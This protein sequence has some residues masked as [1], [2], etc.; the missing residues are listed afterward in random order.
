MKNKKFRIYKY[1]ITQWSDDQKCFVHFYSYGFSP[2]HVLERHKRVMNH[3]QMA[4]ILNI[5]RLKKIRKK[6]LSPLDLEMFTDEAKK[7][8]GVLKF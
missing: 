3:K 8:G 1:D 4:S 7:L 5:K 6:D 2:L